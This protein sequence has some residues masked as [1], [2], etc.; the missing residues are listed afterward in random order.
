GVEQ[1]E[2]LAV[3]L[4][5]PV[6]QV[7]HAVP[8]LGLQVGGMCRGDVV[9]AD[10]AAGGVDVDEQWH[11]FVLWRCSR[12]PLPARHSTPPLGR[13]VHRACSLTW[14]ENPLPHGGGNR[15]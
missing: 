4:V 12:G 8:A 14:G 1:A 13:A 10:W 6:A 9:D 3:R 7:V 15:T 2:D 11:G 5:D